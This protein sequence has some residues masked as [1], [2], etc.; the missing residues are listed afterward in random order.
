MSDWK[1]IVAAAVLG[2]ERQQMPQLTSGGILG[3]TIAAVCTDDRRNKEQKLLAVAA[4]LA[5]HSAAGAMAQK[6]TYPAVLMESDNG[7]GWCECNQKSAEQL[8]A[9]LLP[10]SD[11]GL[12]DQWLECAV[13]SKKLAPPHLIPR[14]LD[15][16]AKDRSVA[17]IMK[18]VGAVGRNLAKLNP[19]WQ[20]LTGE[21][22]SSLPESIDAAWQTGLPG[23]RLG[24]LKNLRAIRSQDARRLVESTWAEDTPK[25]RQAFVDAFAIELSMDDEPFLEEKALMDGRKEVRTAARLLLSRLPHSRYNLRMIDRA[26]ALLTI[27]AN[28]FNLEMPNECDKSMQRDGVELKSSDK[29]LGDKQSWLC[30]MI[31]FINPAH[32]CEKFSLS[33]PELVGLALKSKDWQHLL[34]S[35]WVAAAQLHG[36]AP[37]IEALF[38]V[39]AQIPEYLQEPALLIHL[40]TEQ[41]EKAV[42]TAI[43]AYGGFSTS[44]DSHRLTTLLLAIEATW[45]AP[46]T[47]MI[48][49]LVKKD[50]S[51]PEKVAWEIS[52]AI[53]LIGHRGDT[54]LFPE[55]DGRWDTKAANWPYVYQQVDSAIAFMR[56]RREIIATMNS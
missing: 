34:L 30:Q 10:K 7:E 35:G 44:K 28:D 11:P 27:T 47:R 48:L 8:N 51:I 55:L 18:V 1:S 29:R 39:A 41:K 49:D 6:S 32:W 9:A 24:L 21:Q 33:P 56:E 17:A 14:L 54:G 38:A 26:S 3:V 50:L 4:I 20:Q 19:E 5:V 31:G 43:A 2:S 13:S 12:L 22:S 15:V 52:H 25:D 42:A 16:A 40:S 37:W 46:F 53:T 36:S 45:S 23:E